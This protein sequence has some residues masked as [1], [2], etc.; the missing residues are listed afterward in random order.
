MMALVYFYLCGALGV[1]VISKIYGVW[2]WYLYF[3]QL[4][5]ICW[6]VFKAR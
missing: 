2:V 1:A 4:V 6:A 3:F 5:L